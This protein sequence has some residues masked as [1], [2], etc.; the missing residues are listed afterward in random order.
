MR[1]YASMTIARWRYGL[2]IFYDS[3]ISRDCWCFD[4]KRTSI[5]IVINAILFSMKLTRTNV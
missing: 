1:Q 2:C 3:V 4:K 5:T